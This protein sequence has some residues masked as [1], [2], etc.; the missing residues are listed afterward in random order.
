[1]EVR[2]QTSH[3]AQHQYP[4][5]GPGQPGHG[6]TRTDGHMFMHPSRWRQST[7]FGMQLQKIYVLNSP[8]PH[9]FLLWKHLKYKSAPKMLPVHKDHGAGASSPLCSTPAHHCPVSHRHS[10]CMGEQ[11]ANLWENL[12]VRQGK[13]EVA[14]W[15]PCFTCGIWFK[16]P[17]TSAEKRVCLICLQHLFQLVWVLYDSNG[18]E[19]R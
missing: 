13:L 9:L 12:A 2:Y 8:L 6:A 18:Q 16:N 10:P 15:G 3:L 1:M 4:W 7:W 5:R 19:I 17:L 11:P 14:G